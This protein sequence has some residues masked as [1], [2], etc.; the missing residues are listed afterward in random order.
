MIRPRSVLGLDVGG[1]NLKAA[2]SSSPT[3]LLPFDLWKAP[4][5]LPEALRKLLRELP[6][7]DLLALTMTGELCDC[8]ASRRE[9]VHAILD[10]V[11]TVA[12]SIP[13]QVWLV[14]GRF[15]TLAAAR[16]N[17]LTAAAANW[18]ALATFAGRYVPS[19]PALLI[20]IGSTTTDIVPLLDGKPV[21]RGRNDPE[22]LRAQ[23]LLYT[24]A[25]RTPLCALLAE[26]AAAELFAT[27][28]D[29]YL[30][31]ELV[32]EDPTDC[33]TAD[34]RPATRAA[35]HARLARMI[36]ADLETTTAEERLRLASR[37]A[38]RQ[39][40]LVRRSVDAVVQ[41]MV[42]PPRAVILSGS[43]EFLA[44]QALAL[45]PAFAGTVHSLADILGPHKSCAA[46]AHALAVLAS[47]TSHDA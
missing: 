26:E 30:V 5:A 33:G 17:A 47:E 22:R 12:G 29:A 36:C 7:F 16:A 43:G 37:C 44:R 38:E 25:R 15:V 19:G 1:A 31:L 14:E 46:C 4:A 18:Q 21:P 27:T 24:G 8:F 10:A 34:G 35:A 20:D 32:P 9:G 3:C 13:V 42:G 2:H 41:A 23:E 6:A 28:L 45:L 39:A 11:A 40:R